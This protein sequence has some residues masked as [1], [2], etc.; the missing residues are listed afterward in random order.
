MEKQ[1]NHITLGRVDE[2]LVHTISRPLSEH[3]TGASGPERRN[4]R[5][6]PG[7]YHSA[8]YMSTSL[9]YMDKS[10]EMLCLSPATQPET[11]HHVMSV[12]RGSFVVGSRF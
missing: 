11:H 9:Y 1:K 7:P 8:S 6:N 12:L 5:H 10:P 2:R 4:P 3:E